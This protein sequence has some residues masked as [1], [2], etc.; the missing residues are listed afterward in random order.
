MDDAKREGLDHGVSWQNEGYRYK[1]KNGRDKGWK[2]IETDAD[3]AAFEECQTGNK[4]WTLD[5]KAE[6]AEELGN[7]LL[8]IDEPSALEFLAELKISLQN[9]DLYA[10]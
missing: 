2:Q 7:R 10:P 3:E 4:S 5:S 9:S 8:Q 1:E 6:D